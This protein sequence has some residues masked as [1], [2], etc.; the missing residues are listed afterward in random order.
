MHQGPPGDT[1]GVAGIE[2]DDDTNRA[3]Q[4]TESVH[5]FAL[6]PR[7]SVPGPAGEIPG[8]DEGYEEEDRR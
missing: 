6:L 2:A 4:S 7:D 1:G 5:T 8:G 3:T